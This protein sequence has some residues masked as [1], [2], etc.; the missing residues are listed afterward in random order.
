MQP[1][2][3]IQIKPPSSLPTLVIG[4]TKRPK[5]TGSVKCTIIYMIFLY[6]A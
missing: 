4:G 6:C 5:T 3:K 2:L 1:A